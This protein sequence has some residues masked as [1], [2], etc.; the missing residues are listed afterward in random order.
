MLLGSL[1]FAEL[2]PSAPLGVERGLALLA[3]ALLG[4]GGLLFGLTAV[5]FVNRSSESCSPWSG[6]PLSPAPSS[7]SAEEIAPVLP[8]AQRAKSAIKID[9]S[10]S[11]QVLVSQETV[12]SGDQ[13][14]V[15]KCEYQ[16]RIMTAVTRELITSDLPRSSRDPDSTIKQALKIHQVAVSLAG[17]FAPVLPLDMVSSVVT[18]ACRDL[19][20]EVPAESL[21]EFVH[22][23][24][25][26]RLIDACGADPMCMRMR[27][28]RRRAP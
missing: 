20:G 15:P 22:H 26:Q 1:L 7:G 5:I 10:G 9:S 18:R 17:E 19:S 21:P 14:Q 8:S 6:R 27:Y 3:V 12:N 25:R 11:R 24:A 23:A 13:L 2:A 4:A 16:G 28:G